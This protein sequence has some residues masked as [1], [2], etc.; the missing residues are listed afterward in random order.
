MISESTINKV[1]ELAIED[2]LEPYVRLSKKGSTL[3]GICPFHEERTGSFSVSPG[4][5]LFHCFSCNRGGDAITFIMEKENL[6]FMEAIEF[7]AR[8]H[9]IPIEYMEGQDKEQTAKVRYKETLLAT[10]GHVQDF[11]VSSLLMPD[12]DE[13]RLMLTEDGRKSSVRSQASGMRRVTEVRSWSSAG[14]KGWTRMHFS[15]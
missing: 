7:L 2:V 5:N 1:R 12:N 9:N 15:S 6:S 11:F 4:K 14:Q 3:M 13:S 10:L 8:R